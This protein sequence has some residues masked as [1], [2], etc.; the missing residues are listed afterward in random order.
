MLYDI[1]K[2]AA[3]HNKIIGN[4]LSNRPETTGE[5]KYI[6]ADSLRDALTGADF[7]IISILPGTFDEMESDVHAPE[8]YGIYQSVGDTV[9]PG[10][11]IR[12]LRTVPMF[13]DI[14]EAIREFSPQ[15]WV[16]NYTNPMTICVQTLYRVFPEIKAFGCCHEVFGTQNLLKLALKDVLGIE[17][18]TRQEIH[19]NVKGIN[20][21]TW[22]D[23]ASY[24]GMDLV[25]VYREFTS[26]YHE[27][28]YSEKA[29]TNWMN[30]SFASAERVKM[31]LFCR[32]D[33]IAAAG[34]RHLAEFMPGWYLKN[35]ETV[36]EW[37][38][39]LTTVAWRKKELKERLAKSERLVSGEEELDL[40]KSGEE[41]IM[42]IK[43]LL[44]LGSLVSNVNIPNQGQIGNLPLGAVVET[45]AM[46]DKDSIAPVFAGSLK[47][48]IQHMVMRHVTNQAGILE[49][50]FAKDL[51]LAFNVFMN[52]PL[53]KLDPLEGGALFREMVDNT[54]KYLPGYFL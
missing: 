14:G 52:D 37:M 22:I 6:V 2:T 10:G 48:D 46:F 19:V 36:K 15:A 32:Y 4:K 39:G 13:V 9:G 51:K 3:E 1:D 34:D 23:K 33:V 20:H 8:K 16:I 43:A 25:P 35:P 29:D 24:K 42:L 49:A 54:K 21:F 44:G 31:D 47:P 30:N 7:V 40:K 26:R 53:V 45:N 5:W 27:S 12:A 41:G 18:V 28:G 38:F 50:V 17:G 11:I